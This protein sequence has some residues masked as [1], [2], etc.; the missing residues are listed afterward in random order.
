MIVDALKISLLVVSFATAIVGVV[1]LAAAVLLAKYNFRGKEI[2][3]ALL[4]LP[5]VLP[6]T[7][8]GYYLIVLLGRRGLI[9]G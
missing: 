4:T 3:D 1:G 7:V 2:L 6:P 9:G 5:L 8:T